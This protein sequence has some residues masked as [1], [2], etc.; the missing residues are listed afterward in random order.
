MYVWQIDVEKLATP[1]KN[2]LKRY[3]TIVKFCCCKCAEEVY[4]RFTV[5]MP[6]ISFIMRQGKPDESLS[7]TW[8]LVVLGAYHRGDAA[9]NGA[10]AHPGAA[11]STR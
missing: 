4:A 1:K 10:K 2:I 7:V 6:S 11:A 5:A 8:G 3:K 9:S